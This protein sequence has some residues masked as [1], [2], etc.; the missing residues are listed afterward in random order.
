MRLQLSH[1]PAPQAQRP[2][3]PSPRG[4]RGERARGPCAQEA[5]PRWASSVLAPGG[6]SRGGHRTPRGIPRRLLAVSMGPR[7]PAWGVQS[8]SPASFQG[9][10]RRTGRAYPPVG[11]GAPA[12]SGCAFPSV[13]VSSRS[14][15]SLVLLSRWT[16]PEV[17]A[18][19]P[20]GGYCH[21][22][23]DP[24]PCP[25]LICCSPL[26]T[27]RAPC[28]KLDRGGVAPGLTAARVPGRTGSQSPSPAPPGQ[29]QL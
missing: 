20:R 2:P 15:L 28:V 22:P 12:R 6:P 16:S 4:L 5:S 24:H 10:A 23:R 29:A 18:L 3:N 19:R 14:A 21:P 17:A 8:H 13:G 26:P 27:H 1:T 25:G 7:K 9:L 11:R